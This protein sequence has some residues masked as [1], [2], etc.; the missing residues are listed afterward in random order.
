MKKRH[1]QF[2]AAKKKTKEKE[3]AKSL[4]EFK[5]KWSY[6]VSSLWENW[7]SVGN[8]CE[9]FRFSHHP[10]KKGPKNLALIKLTYSHLDLRSYSLLKQLL[11]P[12]WFLFWQVTVINTGTSLDCQ[13]DSNVATGLGAG[14]FV[15]LLISQLLVMLASRCLCC[16]RGLKPGGSRAW[17]IMLFVACWY[18]L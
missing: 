14:A 9:L 15:F 18:V 13:Y 6:V 7:P 12:F 4:S 17:A 1:L 3:N 16:G 5:T 11:E 2:P 8:K 10:K